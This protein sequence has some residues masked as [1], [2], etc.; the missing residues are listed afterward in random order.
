LVG[1]AS[2]EGVLVEGVESVDV[3]Y[4]NF[5]DDMKALSARLEVIQA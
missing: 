5:V 3:S 2:R 1:V 4:P